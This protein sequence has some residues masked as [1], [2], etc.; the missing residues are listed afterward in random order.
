ME[1][2]VQ[3]SDTLDRIGRGLSPEFYKSFFAYLKRS[4]I[5]SSGLGIDPVSNL[6]KSL[7]VVYDANA[8]QKAIRFGLKNG[9]PSDLI[10]AAQMGFIKPIAPMM[11]DEE[12]SEHAQEMA[13]ALG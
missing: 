13:E 6:R 9:K 1:P 7:T 11:L 3:V 5:K 4:V 12:I 2:A 8:V 10:D